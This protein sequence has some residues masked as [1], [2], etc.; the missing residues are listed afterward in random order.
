MQPAL[1]IGA[2]PAA[3]P[4]PIQRP[5]LLPAFTNPARRPVDPTATPIPEP[6][7]TLHITSGPSAWRGFVVAAEDRCSPYD[8]DDYPYPQSVEPRIGA[9]MGG[10]IYGRYTGTWF[11]STSATYIEHIVGRSEAHDSGHCAADAATKRRSASHLANLTLPSPTVK[12]SQKGDKDPAEWLPDL[13]RRWF[14][15]RVVQ[16]R[17]RF[18]PTVD[19]RERDVLEGIASGCT[20]TGMML[21]QSDPAQTATPVP[22][23]EKGL[24]GDAL[25]SMTT[26]GT[27]ASPARRHGVPPRSTRSSRVPPASMTGTTIRS[28]VS[29]CG[30]MPST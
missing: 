17:Q 9:G 2:H 16:V 20:S 28:Y 24:P 27:A 21:Q 18:G 19:R 5:L 11:D 25:H 29:E 10:V 8:S 6:T 30:E 7:A 4:H 15:D 13:N 1:R 22:A 14:A 3:T 23:L 12:R 26:T